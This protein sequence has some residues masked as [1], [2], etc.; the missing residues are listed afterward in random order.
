MLTES[1]I[2][3]LKPRD[4]KYKVADGDNLYLQVNPSG[5]KSWKFRYN[6]GGVS[7]EH[8][9]GEYSNISLAEARRKKVDDQRLLL[10]NIDPCSHH[11]EKK[12]LAETRDRNTFRMV[13][14]EWFEWRKPYWTPKHAHDTW[15]RLER[16]ALPLL[17][18][19]PIAEIQTVELHA[20]IRQI[21]NKGA[22]HMSKRVFQICN[23]VFRYAG[24]TGRLKLN[25]ADHLKGALAPHRTQHYP[26]L[27]ARE[28]PDFL[29]AFRKLSSTE[30]NKLAFMIL[31]HTAV[32]T[33]ELRYAE[34]SE[35]DWEQKLWVIP[36]EKMKMRRDHTVP[37][38]ATVEKL[39]LRLRAITTSNQ[40]LFPNQQARKHPVMSENTI[41]DMIERMGYKNRIVGHGFRSLFSTILNEEG[42]YRRDAIE[43]Q[44]AHV[45]KNQVRAA[46]NRALYL[47]ERREMMSWWSRYL[48]DL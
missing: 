24:M 34:W 26:T 8:T 11:L 25:P 32:R 4:K 22:T 7:R 46:Y 19:R 37:I 12:L 44:L 17:G 3:A 45:E 27:L 31:L 42:R 47:E 29:S 35:I 6:F 10:D 13:A 14:E 48:D 9:L 36:A 2:K 39:L 28:L 1:K 40:Y 30:Q 16:H 33:A 15:R 20:V 38:T 41:N 5:K 21:E 23:G 43:M 18:R